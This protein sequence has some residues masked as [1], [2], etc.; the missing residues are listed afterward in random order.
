MGG[1]RAGRGEERGV[2]GASHSPVSPPGEGEGGEGGGLPNYRGGG[3]EPTKS[4]AVRPASE[5]TGRWIQI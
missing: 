1:K 2:A 3:L 5:K 4:T